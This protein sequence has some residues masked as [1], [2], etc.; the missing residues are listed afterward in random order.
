MFGSF[1]LPREARRQRKRHRGTEDG[2]GG[3]EEGAMEAN[4]EVRSAAAGSPAVVGILTL[5]PH[6]NAYESDIEQTLITQQDIQAKLAELDERI[7]DDY[8]GRDLL[9][10]GVLKGAFVM[11]ADLARYIRLPLEFDFM[12]VSSYGA[13]TQ[14]SGVVRIL[15]D[16][17]HDIEGRNVL[18]VEDIVDSGLTLSYLMKNLRTR[19]PAS[20]E[21]CALMQK[22]DVQQVPLDIKY[23]AFEIPPVFVVGYGLDYGER[24]RNLPFVG[25]LR[26]E[27]YRDAVS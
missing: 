11:M 20:I 19:K 16:L 6:V 22:T 27:V 4:A 17:D 18:I 8:R 21:V 24:F 9:L 13:A 14:T 5:P 3:R 15:K 12:A 7:S 2:R 10:V 26:P 1:A 23:K 25:T